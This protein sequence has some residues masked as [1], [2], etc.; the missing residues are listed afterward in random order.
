M[1]NAERANLVQSLAE[2]LGA[3]DLYDTRLSGKS[4]YNADTG[5]FYCEGITL[6]HSSIESIKAWHRQQMLNYKAT[7]ASDPIK[8]EFYM[9]YAVAYNAICM[10]EDNLDT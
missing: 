1:N 6:P 10:M 5:T 7:A 3:T 9:R 4:R 8:M 2:S